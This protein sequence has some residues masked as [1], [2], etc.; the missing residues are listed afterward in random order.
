MQSPSSAFDPV[1]RTYD[2]SFTQSVTGSLQRNRVWKYL[3]TLSMEGSQNKV[4]E[5]NCGTGEDAVWLCKK[6]F[7]VT[8]TDLSAEML[9]I[10]EG[11]RKNISNNNLQFI[12][13]DMREIAGHF[14]PNKFDFIFSDFGGLNCLN[15]PEIRK[16]SS[17][18]QGLLKP[19]GNL[20]IVLM[21]RSCLWERFYFFAKGKFKQAF[22]RKNRNGLDVQLGNS[23]QKTFYYSPSDFME[24]LGSGWTK[25]KQRPIGLFLPPSYLDAYFIK[26][27]VQLK[28]LER[29]ERMFGSIGW[30]S[31]TAD[32]YLIHCRRDIPPDPAGLQNSEPGYLNQ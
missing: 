2:T 31:D 4:L 19:G 3:D 21:S 28:I 16:L 29:L 8:A 1:A 32:H 20:V 18:L 9:A 26:H 27:P 6:G 15:E 12:K 13:C 11:K 10:A 17:D 7:I 24:L 23:I 30:L 5:L 14:S 22:R 25:I